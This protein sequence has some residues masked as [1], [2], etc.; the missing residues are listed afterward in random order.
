MTRTALLLLLW[1]L[2]IACGAASRRAQQEPAASSG[3]GAG[4][5]TATK[6]PSSAPEE[7]AGTGAPAAVGGRGAAGVAGEPSQS[8]A[9]FHEVRV[10]LENQTPNPIVVGGPCVGPWVTFEREGMKLQSYLYCANQCPDPPFSCP[11][12]C[13]DNQEIVPPGKSVSFTWDG[14]VMEQKGSCYERRHPEPGSK[15]T[16]RACWNPAQ[17]GSAG[18]CVSA[19]FDYGK[20]G[21]ITLRATPREPSQTS[22]KLVLR[23]TNDQPIEIIKKTCE[24][25]GVF[26]VRGKEQVLS[27]NCGCV[28]TAD[29]LVQGC[30]TVSCGVCPPDEV[31]L[32]QPGQRFEFA[33]DRKY[34][35]APKPSCMLQYR[36]QPDDFAPMQACWREPPYPDMVCARF[37]LRGSEATLTVDAKASP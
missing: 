10:T 16:A 31:E 7:S 32:L 29:T 24:S 25:Q 21:D 2:L 4:G 28:C 5:T 9:G 8:S 20:D 23:N 13:S 26:S 1:S 30:P 12:I 34:W 27:A 36:L 14:S 19:T 18:E 15:L 17:W 37:D 35:S 22:T 11:A 33:W 6:P 3:A